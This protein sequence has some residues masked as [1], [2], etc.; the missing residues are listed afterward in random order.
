MLEYTAY[1]KQNYTECLYYTN[2]NVD[3]YVSTK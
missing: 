2:S 1:Q 3:K